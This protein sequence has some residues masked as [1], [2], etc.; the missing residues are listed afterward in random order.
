[1]SIEIVRELNVVSA[2]L[3]AKLFINAI[4]NGDVDFVRTMRDT[5]VELYSVLIEMAEGK[6]DYP[7]WYDVFYKANTNSPLITMDT[8]GEFAAIVEK[9]KDLDM[10]GYYFAEVMPVIRNGVEPLRIER[11]TVLA[12]LDE[13]INMCVNTRRAGFKLV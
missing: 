7:Q 3:G 9:L 6:A 5:T 12:H 8:S 11:D 1:M 13:A 10:T 4:T 2:K